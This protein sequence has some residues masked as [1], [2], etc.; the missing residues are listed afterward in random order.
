[1]RVGFSIVAGAVASVLMC[2]G[3]VVA[4]F[5]RITA[6]TAQWELADTDH[7][8]TVSIGNHSPDP[9]T[10]CN[11]MP[12]L[13]CADAADLVTITENLDNAGEDWFFTA[14]VIVKVLSAPDAEHPLPDAPLRIG[15]SLKA[16]KVY[17]RSSGEAP[18]VAGR[19]PRA[20]DEIALNADLAT[21][22]GVDVGDTVLPKD[23]DPADTFAPLHFTVT[24][25]TAIATTYI[26][27]STVAAGYPTFVI[28]SPYVVVSLPHSLRSLVSTIS[29]P[30]AQSIGTAHP[31]L[32][33]P[34]SRT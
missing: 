19:A 5:E 4:H 25:L 34:S 28:G 8:A 31:N 1:M 27:F 21:Q 29:P 23:R 3:F 6:E 14:N 18:M 30:S 33:R 11:R 13:V 22:L 26:P 32:S 2:F 17:A 20:G 16:I 10:A 15:L 7:M 12:S 9:G 24:G